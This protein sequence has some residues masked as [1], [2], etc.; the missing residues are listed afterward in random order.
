MKHFRLCAVLLALTPLAVCPAPAQAP[1]KAPSPAAPIL[2]GPVTHIRIVGLKNVSLATVQ[3]KLTLKV[4]DAY[5]PEAAQKD[6]AAVQSI[7]VFNGQVTAAATPASP[8]GVDLTYTV[9]ENPVVQSIHIT[10]NTPSGLPS[11]PAAELMAQMKTKVGKVLNTSSLVSD[12]DSLFNHTNGYVT[13][14]G[15]IF[16]VSPDINIEPTTGVLT[17]PLIEAYVKSI[18][19][20]GNSRVKTADILAQMHTKPDAL[21]NI[22]TLEEDKSSIY[23]MGEFKQ[24]DASLNAA[25]TGKSSVTVSVVEQPAATGVLDEKQGKVI[26]FLYD[27]L[28]SPFPVIQVSVNG[29]SPLPFILDTGTSPAL[30]LNPWA[31][32]ELGLKEDGKIEAGAGFTFTRVAIRSVVLQGRDHNSDVSFDAKEAVVLD[33]SF[34]SQFTLARHIA[35]IVGMGMLLPV[36]SRFDFA[37]KTLTLFAAKH[38]PLHIAGGTVLPMRGGSGGIFT[39]RATLAPNAYADLIIDTGSD[40]TQVPLS[41]LPALHPTAL[42]FNSYYERIDGT[43]LCPEMRLPNLTLGALPVLDAVVG[44]L[45]PPTRLSLGMDILAGYRLTLDGP[46]GQL[47]MKPSAHGGRHV[48]GWSGLDVTL[49]GKNWTVSRVRQDA[50]AQR[51]GLQVGDEITTV[52]GITAQDLSQLQIERILAG[53]AGVPLSVVVKRNQGRRIAISWVP[54]DNFSSPRD[55]MY[56]LPLQKSPGDPWI[57]SEIIKGCPGDKAGLLAGD[58]LT[59]IDGEATATMSLVRFAELTSKSPVL[60]EVERPGVAKLFTAR[61]TVPK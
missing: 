58:T 31:T 40:G 13:K 28:T 7:G 22:N 26:P 45:P 25:D 9:R 46:N 2:T 43:Y 42:A 38:P 54:A 17:I 36:T 51:G 3:A 44:T 55:M 1:A 21:Y 20:T 14:Q 15:Y 8:N 57:I 6:A 49:S 29:H 12:L 39:V 5:T 32:Q 35:G 48:H 24:V 56:G 37:A 59:K 10:A 18:E 41:A 33:V 50:P 47:I 19:V 16:D 11:V 52:Y 4:G 23:E 34:L 30:S 60:V 27:P 61:L 53:I